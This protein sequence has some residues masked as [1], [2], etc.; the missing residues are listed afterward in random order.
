MKSLHTLRPQLIQAVY[1]FGKLAPCHDTIHDGYGPEERNGQYGHNDCLRRILSY[2]AEPIFYCECPNI[3]CKTETAHYF[4]SKSTSTKHIGDYYP[5]APWLTICNNCDAGAHP[6]FDSTMVDTRINPCMGTPQDTQYRIGD[7][8]PI[9]RH[10]F[11]P[12]PMPDHDICQVCND[13]Y[14]DGDHW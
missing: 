8:E 3:T 14:D 10:D 7:P 11:N 6:T 13:N 9:Q 1:W 12:Y 5:E 2:N 4:Q